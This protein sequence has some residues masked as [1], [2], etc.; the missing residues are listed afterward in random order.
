MDFEGEEEDPEL[1]D[2]LPAWDPAERGDP[3]LLSGS[4]GEEEGGAAGAED[5]E[6]LGAGRGGREAGEL[7]A[8]PLEEVQVRVLRAWRRPRVHRPPPAHPS[9][10]PVLLT[11]PVPC[12]P[13][14]SP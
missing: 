14:D 4:E 10:A 12:L 3:L 5:E 13:P 9:A 2:V 7:P 8:H 11:A 1:R 6:D